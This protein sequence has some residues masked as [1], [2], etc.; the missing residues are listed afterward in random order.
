MA[1]EKYPIEVIVH[2]PSLYCKKQYYLDLEAQIL[3]A[4][5]NKKV[6]YKK[7]EYLKYIE[8]LKKNFDFSFL[9]NIKENLVDNIRSLVDSNFKEIC[10]GCGSLK[11]PMTPSQRCS[12]C[13]FIQLNYC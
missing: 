1:C 10:S 4:L 5:K 13:E 2:E 3:Y 9:D 7:H 8:Y 12:T 11:K 6:T